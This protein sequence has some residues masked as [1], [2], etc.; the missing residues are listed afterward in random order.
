MKLG[1]AAGSVLA[2]A[3]AATLSGTP[4]AAQGYPP[5]P[6]PSRYDSGYRVELT[7]T[8]SYRFG[9]ELAG[10]DDAFFDTDLEV[11]EGVA[12]G[13][14]LDIPLSSSLQLELLANR[15]SSEL[16]FDEDLFGS[17]TGVADIDVSYYH[18]GLLWQGR[19]PRITPFFVASAG[20]ANLD[21]DVPGAS[22]ED[23]FS[24]SLGG[25]VKVFFSDNVGLRFEGRG[26]V[27]DFDSDDRDRDDFCDYDDRYDDNCY[28]E[29]FSQGQVSVGLIFA[30]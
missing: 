7:P 1:I 2:A 26:F 11:D 14:T 16:Q 24:L 22:S 17:E 27:S 12:Y 13:V 23:R 28:D 8:V 3:I 30:W 20:I 25:G 6:Y 10:G 4:L 9:G 29:S 19:H 21:P 15:Q 5:A 18:V